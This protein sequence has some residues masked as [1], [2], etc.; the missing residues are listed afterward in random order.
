MADRDEIEWIKKNEPWRLKK[1]PQKA[2]KRE[3]GE[4]SKEDD[5]D[6]KKE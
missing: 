2:L 4:S 3:S 5:L 1:K 6:K